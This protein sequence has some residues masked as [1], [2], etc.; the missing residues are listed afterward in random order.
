MAG[1]IIAGMVN[2]RRNHKRIPPDYS[3]NRSPSIIKTISMPLDVFMAVN[4]LAK[5][6]R[7]K[8]STTVVWLIQKGIAH[9]IMI[10]EEIKRNNKYRKEEQ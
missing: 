3:D 5:E 7:M 1:Q 4:E 2:N 8:F 9:E 10:Q 6:N